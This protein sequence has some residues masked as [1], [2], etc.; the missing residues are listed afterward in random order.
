M[1]NWINKFQASGAMKP[2]RIAGIKELI[3]AEWYKL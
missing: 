2:D 3:K 1:K